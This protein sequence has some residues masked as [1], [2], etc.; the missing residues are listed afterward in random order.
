[1]TL[2][3]GH[4]DQDSAPERDALA[5]WLLGHH[6]RISFDRPY[7]RG[8]RVVVDAVV[9][10]ACRYL[11]TAEDGNERD[12]TQ[13]RCRAHG[14]AGMVPPRRA[15]KQP[16]LQHPDGTLTLVH[17][18]R[19]RR[20]ALPKRPAPARTLPVLDAPN[21]CLSAPCRTADHTR[22][23]ACCR[24]LTLEVV[25]PAQSARSDHLEALLLARR[26]PYL[27]K[28]ERVDADIIECEVISA[29]GYLERDG[30]SCALHHR[31]R[32]DGKPAKPEVCSAWPALGPDAVGHPGCVLIPGTARRR[33]GGTA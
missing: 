30:T 20:I 1:M 6:Q 28:T 3:I 17:R 11:V 19:S 14:F 18:G 21:P 15:A 7:R 10:A 5:T 16:P 9:H 22:G 32:P 2:S 8:R 25:A 13:A 29:C 4:L 24:D 26:S 23:A 31:L 12:A 27:C 33:N